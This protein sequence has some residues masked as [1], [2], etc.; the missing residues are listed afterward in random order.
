[1]CVRLPARWRTALG[2]Q[3]FGNLGFF[4]GRKLALFITYTLRRFRGR[5]YGLCRGFWRYRLSLFFI[6][7]KS[8]F[9]GFAEV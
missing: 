2:L 8:R 5:L 1:L 3:F 4:T 6:G 9:K 7:C